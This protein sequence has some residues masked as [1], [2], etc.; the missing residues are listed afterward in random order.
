MFFATAIPVISAKW[1]WSK[2]LSTKEADVQNVAGIEDIENGSELPD[3][4]PSQIGCRNFT[5]WHAL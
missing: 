1:G 4:N 2:G 5:P 3:I